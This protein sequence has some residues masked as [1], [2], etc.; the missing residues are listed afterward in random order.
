MK[1]ESKRWNRVL[2]ATS[3][4]F[5][6]FPSLYDDSIGMS[7]SVTIEKLQIT[8]QMMTKRRE[9]VL[10]PNDSV[11]IIRTTDTEGLSLPVSPS[12]RKKKG[13]M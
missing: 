6:N 3:Y 10:H 7:Y 12:P 11:R 5:D 8:I 13:A 4:Y 1:V 9:A 2:F